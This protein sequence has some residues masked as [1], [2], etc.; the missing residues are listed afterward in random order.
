M[1]K[2]TNPVVYI[3]PPNF[4]NDNNLINLFSFKDFKMEIKQ[5]DKKDD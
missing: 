3:S 2:E 5:S 4:N 1:N